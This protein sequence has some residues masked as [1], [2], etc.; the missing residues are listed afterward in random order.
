MK[1]L[2]DKNVKLKTIKIIENSVIFL[3]DG[4]KKTYD[5]IYPTN[6]GIFTGGGFFAENFN[7]I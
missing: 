6:K 7:E 1:Q 3:K 5:A 2:K 4:N